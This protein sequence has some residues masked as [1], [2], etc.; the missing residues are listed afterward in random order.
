MSRQLNRKFGAIDPS[1]L[2]RLQGLTKA[3]L[4]ALGEDFLD[5]SDI[6]DLEACFNR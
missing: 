1:I 5:F 6:S 2:E 3:Q 4:E